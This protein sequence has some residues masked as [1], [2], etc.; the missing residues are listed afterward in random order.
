[1]K[2]LFRISLAALFGALFLLPA[3]ADV[4]IPRSEIDSGDIL[5]LVGFLLLFIA[6]IAAV[7]LIANKKRK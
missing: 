7:I 5:G 3:N 1:M 4:Y 6:A 2:H